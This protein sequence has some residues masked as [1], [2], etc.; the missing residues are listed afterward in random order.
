[1]GVDLNTGELAVL[2]DDVRIPTLNLKPLERKLRVE[3]RKLSRRYE[4][5]KIE[6]AHDKLVCPDNVRELTDFPNYQRQRRLV[7]RIHAKIKHKRRNYLQ[8]VTTWLVRHYDTIVIE[9]LKVSNMVKNHHLARKIE[10]QSWY[11]FRRELIYKCAWYG[12]QLI[13]VDP[14]NTSRICSQC[15]K[16]N[17]QFDELDTNQWL[18]TRQWT[19]PCCGA[20]HDRDINAANNILNKGLAPTN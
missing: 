5:A 20:H 9:D 18:S 12:K 3:Q 19:C 14:K 13:I 15:G 17:H 2:S 16:K 6:R 1:M 8:Q 11:E 4:R 10:H 7:A